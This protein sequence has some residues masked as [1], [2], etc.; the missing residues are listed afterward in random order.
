MRKSA[1]N[2]AP[3]YSLQAWIAVAEDGTDTLGRQRL[4]NRREAFAGGQDV[5][6]HQQRHAPAVAGEVPAEP[7][8]ADVAAD[9]DFAAVHRLFD[10]CARIGV[11]ERFAADLAGQGTGDIVDDASG[12]LAFFQADQRHAP[13][14]HYREAQRRCGAVASRGRLG[15]GELEQEQRRGDE[16]GCEY[17]RE[18]SSHCHGRGLMEGRAN[19]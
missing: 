6:L 11:V 16:T 13:A 7:G 8:G 15:R 14:F 12:R 9:V 2:F 5:A 1:P 3:R 19:S 17:G 10:T 4:G 18:R